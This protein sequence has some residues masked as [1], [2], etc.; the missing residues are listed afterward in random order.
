[1]SLFSLLLRLGLLRVGRFCGGLFA[2]A[3]GLAAVAHE[4]LLG[5]SQIVGGACGGGVIEHD[6]LA[7]RGGLAETYVS[8]DDGVE[9]Q[10]AEV[11]AHLGGDLVVQAVA[12][13]HRQHETLDLEVGVEAALDDL[14]GVEQLAQTLEGQILALYGYEDR[15]CG[16]EDVDGCISERGR[17]VDED[18]VEAL[19][20]A[21]DDA[22]NDEM[23]VLHLW[24]FGVC[25]HEVYARRQQPEVLD[26]GA[27]AYDLLGAFFAHDA[28]IYAFE[29]DVES[30]SGRCVCL[31]VGVE[32]Q[33]FASEQGER[34][35]EV[36]GGGGFA[37]TA[38]LVC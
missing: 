27:L 1:M 35:G 11:F 10:R 5:Q 8:L 29:V 37:D 13:V 30:E 21:V 16:G 23:S 38:L 28:L 7:V 14:D 19:A 22:L 24:Q 4:Q 6:G 36:Y 3:S 25:G 32:Q 33:D 2:G 9:G 15:I 31:W 20:H 18:E 17:T 12:H 26:I 34:G